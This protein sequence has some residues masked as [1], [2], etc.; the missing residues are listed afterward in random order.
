M[1]D[2]Y[3]QIEM[4]TE[5]LFNTR[6]EVAGLK[7]ENERLR[8]ALRDALK[9]YAKTDDAAPWRINKWSELKEALGEDE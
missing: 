9:L 7:A 3:I 6:K 2:E 5:T 4:L 1:S 8:A